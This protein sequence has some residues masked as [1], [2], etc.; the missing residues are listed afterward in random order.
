MEFI[1]PQP[2]YTVEQSN[3]KVVITMEGKVPTANK[4]MMAGFM[5]WFV[6]Y[7]YYKLGSSSNIPFWVFP[8]VL[9]LGA[10]G[11]GIGAL[12]AR[13]GIHKNMGI[14]RIILDKGS[15]RVEAPFDNFVVPFEK[16]RD[17][18]ITETKGF[19]TTQNLLKFNMDQG[20]KTLSFPF[21]SYAKA[22]EI[23][24]VINSNIK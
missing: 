5:V 13:K 21:M 3:N 14:R 23:L 22:E 1:N 7:S 4:Y 12:I 20:E 2:K 8:F 24:G 19:L 18:K 6:L 10:F 11:F 9:L 16:I 15:K 17:I